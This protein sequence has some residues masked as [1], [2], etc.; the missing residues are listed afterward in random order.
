M[1]RHLAL[2]LAILAVSLPARLYAQ[3][4]ADSGTFVIRHGADTVATERFARSATTITGTLAV[5]NADSTSQWYSAVLAPD[6]SVPMIEVTVRQNADSGRVK[7][8]VISRARVVFKEDSAAVD[9]A[10]GTGLR[11]YVFGTQRGAIPYLNLSFAL[12]EQA[13]RQARVPS[14]ASQVPLFNLGGGQTLDGKLAGLGADSVTLAIGKV[15]YHLRVDAAGRL[16]GAR[17]PT[18]DVVVSRIGGS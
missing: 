17:I 12:L 18:Q 6:G 9:E 15:E 8:K 7:G 11:T 1:N 5:R 10:N 3:A 2:V 4:A 13:V 16:L 14:S